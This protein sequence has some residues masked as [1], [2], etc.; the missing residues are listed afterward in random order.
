MGSFPVTYKDALKFSTILSATLQ[1][2]FAKEGEIELS[3]TPTLQ[4]SLSLVGNTKTIAFED[5]LERV[6]LTSLV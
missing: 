4:L 2:R 6:A 1:L 3:C 5:H